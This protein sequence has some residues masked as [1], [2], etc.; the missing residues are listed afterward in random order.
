VKF[1]TFHH[2]GNAAQRHEERRK[3]AENM[4]LRGS[5]R[6]PEPPRSLLAQGGARKVVVTWAPPKN[7]AEIVGWNVYKDTES[8]FYAHIGSRDIRRVDINV[9]TSA[10]PSAAAV[11]VCSVS[12]QG[13]E[14]EKMQVMGTPLAETGAPADPAPSPEVNPEGSTSKSWRYYYYGGID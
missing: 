3:A 5:E 13:R 11:Y 14:S 12:A 6:R 7:S 10:S 9:N 8:Q 1:P 2:T 4:R